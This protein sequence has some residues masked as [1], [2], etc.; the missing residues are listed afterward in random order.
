MSGFMPG[1]RPRRRFITLVALKFAAGSLIAKDQ[2]KG[3]HQGALPAGKSKKVFC[4]RPAALPLM[5]ILPGRGRRWP[6]RHSM[7]IGVNL[8]DALS[9]WRKLGT[10]NRT[11]EEQIKMPKAAVS[12]GKASASTKSR[13]VHFRIR[14]AVRLVWEQP[15]PKRTAGPQCM[16]RL[17]TVDVKSPAP[18]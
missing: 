7:R 10:D 3:H 8:P 12:Q 18:P 9:A 13:T 6:C 11:V 5:E 14:A 15:R 17:A 4:H 16:N 1:S 2:P